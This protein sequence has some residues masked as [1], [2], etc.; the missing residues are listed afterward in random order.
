MSQSHSCL[1]LIAG[2]GPAGLTLACDLA[3]RGISFRIVDK[4]DRL[5][6]GSR[7]KGLQPRTLEVFHDLDVID[8]IIAAGAPFPGFRC[9]AGEQVVWDRSLAQMIGIREPV[10]T[11]GVPYPSAW[12]IPQWR[13]DEVLHNRLIRLGR[14]VELSTELVAFE[15]DADGVTATLV[16]DGVQE[17]VRAR[18]LVGTDGGRSFVRKELGV[19]FEGETFET[20]R[21]IIGDVRVDGPLDH[22]HCHLLTRAGGISSPERFSLWGLPGTEFFQLVA[23]VSSDDVP[24]LTLDA[25]QA[26]LEA[27]SGRSDI[28]LHDL[29]WISLY[30][31]NV[32]M[33]ERFRVGRVFLAGDA[34][35]VHSSAGGQGL[36][37]SVQDAY[38]LGWKLGAVLAGAPVELLD[39]Y[40]A[41]RMPVAADLLGITTRWHRQD[42]GGPPAGA[43]VG[44]GHKMFQLSLNYRGSPL[45]WDDRAAPSGLRAGDRAPDAPCSGVGDVPTRL[46]DVFRG[47]HF[48]L[49]AFGA[50]S[51]DVATEINN[52]RHRD[53]VRVYQVVLPS[54]GS[55]SA[56]LIDSEGFIH[57]AYEIDPS[58]DATK[59]VLVRP[60]GYIGLITGEENSATARLMRYLEMVAP[61]GAS[62]DGVE[63]NASR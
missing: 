49:L 10:A 57:R 63:L 18:Y 56:C 62:G 16:R 37:A 24:A 34:A 23:N 61:I 2:A 1:V 55:E 32:R 52:S 39:T 6:I 44:S 5:F 27:R 54:R 60:D 11:P 7:G 14:N 38:N 58:T 13:T 22:D 9:Y 36:N 28:R 21:T 46:F 15:Q 33:A 19:G 53:F 50:R 29:R 12:I 35:H 42:F 4:A 8:D 20:E 45:A 25:M 43:E 40:E 41:E 31:V 59:L 26:M 47:P 51:H 48:T 17:R 30:R 3:R